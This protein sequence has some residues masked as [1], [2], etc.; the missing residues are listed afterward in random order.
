MSKINPEMIVLARESR[1]MTQGE[2]AE[3]IGVS[4]GKVS[5]YEHGLLQVS[6]DDLEKISKVLGYTIEFFFQIDKVYGLGHSMLFH[7]QRQDVP[8]LVQKRIQGEVNI[9]RMQ[10]E[11]LLLSAEVESEFRIEPIDL[12]L[13]GGEVEQIAGLV[14]DSWRLPI[15]PVQNMTQVIE[16]AG[17]VILKKDFGSNGVDAAHLWVPGQPPMFFMNSR[18][19][20]DRYRWNLAHE[21]GHAVMHRYPTD[22][23]EREAHRFAAEF[24]MPAADMDHH[25]TGLTLEKAARLK[26]HWKVSMASIIKRA[27]DLRKISERQYRSLFTKLSAAGYRTNEPITLE[28]EE[29]QLIPQLID[30]Y[31]Q[32]FGYSPEDM[33]RLFFERDSTVAGVAGRIGPHVQLTGLGYRFPGIPKKGSA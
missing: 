30:L 7:R 8:V 17:G 33:R 15:G 22:D 11:R 1:G 23:I 18:V 14:R 5:K 24:L 32:S 20:T 26:I 3:S 25:L 2:L 6:E 12:E 16:A 13:H 31:R 4:Q 29:P 28:A 10:V 21:L 9:S 27:A 19:P